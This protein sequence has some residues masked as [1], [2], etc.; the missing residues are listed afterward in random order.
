MLFSAKGKT[1]HVFTKDADTLVFL[2]LRK[3]IIN[4]VNVEPNI[5]NIQRYSAYVMVRY[6]NSIEFIEL[7]SNKTLDTIQK[8]QLSEKV[9]N[10]QI[11]ISNQR[12]LFV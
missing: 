2:N 8:I 3:E 5:R 9:L 7:D 1:Y 11:D 6:D 12:F 10:T 4:M